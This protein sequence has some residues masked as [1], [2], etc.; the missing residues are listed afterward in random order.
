[1]KRIYMQINIWGA[2]ALLC[3]ALPSMA[4]AQ[5]ETDPIRNTQ[6][7]LRGSA[8]FQSMA[9][10]FGSLG[11]D[12]SSTKQNP[13]GIALMRS[14]MDL[15][16]TLSAYSTKFK[17]SWTGSNNDK[18]KGGVDF[19][20][21]SFASCS[22]RSYSGWSFS[23]GFGLQKD[24]IFDRKIDIKGGFDNAGSIHSLGDY[25]AGLLNLTALGNGGYNSITKKDLLGDDAYSRYPWAPVLGYDAGFI[26]SDTDKGGPYYSRFRYGAGAGKPVGPSTASMV[27]T[28]KGATTNF[29]F[30]FGA[31]Y[32]ERVYI[33]GSF[34]YSTF[35]RE[36]TSAYNESFVKPDYLYLENYQKTTGGG[37]GGSLGVIVQPFDGFKLGLSY[38]TPMFYSLTDKYSGYAETHYKIPVEPSTTNLF[39]KANTP[40]GGSTDF[41]L[42]TNGRFVGSASYVFG[43]YG[44]LSVDY[45]YTNFADVKLKSPDENDGY[46]YT[47]LALKDDFGAQHTLRIGAEARPTDRLSVRAGYMMR[48]SPIKDERIKNTDGPATKEIYIDRTLPHYTLDKGV[49]AITA[50]VGFRITPKFTADLALV[51]TTN[52]SYTYSFPSINDKDV[53]VTSLPPIKTDRNDLHLALTLGYRL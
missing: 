42:T 36:I 52:K 17:S 51:W 48:T 4:N 27:L 39:T 29:D 28:E 7:E 22:R 43:R 15:S 8:R 21:F 46:K 53:K 38:F 24:A 40:N 25:F 30:T 50:G 33:G 3:L 14:P 1:M 12:Y 31:N 9:G 5:S 37:V 32:D 41:D 47:N 19:D 49:S 6:K 23:Y 10:A 35:Y 11:G 2:V 20:A 26:T 44:L 34:I 18:T 16:L 45:E 13:A